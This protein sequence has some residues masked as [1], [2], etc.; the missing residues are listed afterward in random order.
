MVPISEKYMGF[1]F[2]KVI[3]VGR[4]VGSVSRK[5][6][7]KRVYPMYYQYAKRKTW[8]AYCDLYSVF[9]FLWFVLRKDAGAKNER[10]WTSY[11]RNATARACSGL[12]VFICA[13]LF[14]YESSSS[15]LTQISIYLPALVAVVPFG[16]RLITFAEDA[17]SAGLDICAR[18]VLYF[19]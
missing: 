4:S 15:S 16:A 18:L 17:F 3:I 2:L 12:C 6:Q 11:P 8:L 5:C 7:E 19:A 10:R 1:H 13:Y 9:W 14:I